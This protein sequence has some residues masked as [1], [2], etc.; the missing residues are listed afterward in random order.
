M[1]P[2]IRFSVSPM[3]VM[4]NKLYF[5][6]D[7]R[8]NPY[9]NLALEHYFTRTVPEGCLVFYLWQN[10]RTVVVGRNQNLM[11]ECRVDKLLE[12]G[13]HPCRRLSGGGAVYHDLGNLNFSFCA[14]SGVYDVATQLLV[15][16]KALSAFDL[17]SQV[18]GRNDLIVNGRKV[19]GGAYLT[20]GKQHCHHGTLLV[21]V[22]VEDMAKY[23]T[24]SAA[25]LKAKGVSSVKSRVQNLAQMSPAVT[26]GHLCTELQKAAS[27]VY[28]TAVEVIPKERIDWKSVE[29]EAERFSSQDWLYGHEPPMTAQSLVHRFDWGCAKLKIAADKGVVKRAWLETDA[30]DGEIGKTVSSLLENQPFHKE[31]LCQACQEAS[32]MASHAASQEASHVASQAPCHLACRM[33]INTS[34]SLGE[35][36]AVLVE[37]MFDGEV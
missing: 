19:S 8:T 23:L 2:G 32:Q 28:G 29:E 24:P 20:E 33:A 11:A 7:D 25:K 15:I 26:V 13:G 34:K 6:Q 27:H 4:T 14:Q 31:A 1:R 22:N 5:Y 21:N 35:D 9:R 3:T 10:Q 18:S 17:P 12:D 36:L 30:T 37:D 16:Q